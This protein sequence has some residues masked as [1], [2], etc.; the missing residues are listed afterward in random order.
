MSNVK[1]PPNLETKFLPRDP[2][3]LTKVETSF[4][5]QK[6]MQTIGIELRHIQA[7]SV[8]LRMPYAEQFTQQHGF[9]HAGIM[10][11][12]LD[13]ACGYAAFSLMEKGAEVLTVEF[14]TNLLSPAKGD[15]FSFRAKVLKPGKTLTVCEAQAFAIQDG[16]EKLVASMNATLMAV[17]GRADIRG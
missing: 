10:T 2:D 7:G 6:A 12:A 15:A 14:K 3:F 11:T 8:E 5:R 1:T 13:S 4:A 9:I 17:D 16:E